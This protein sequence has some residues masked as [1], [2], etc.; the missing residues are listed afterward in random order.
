MRTLRYGSVPFINAWPLTRGLDLAYSE[1]P[2]R[3]AGR[4]RRG[5]VDVALLSSFE[6]FR[7]GTSAIVPGIAI[8]S[9]GPVGSV[10]LFR[11]GPRE[12]LRRVRV[13][14]SSL[15][16]AALVRLLLPEGVEFVPCRPELDPREA[17]GDGVLLIGD[18]AMVAPRDGLV[19]DDLAT[20]WMAE[21]GLP[22]TFAVW[23]A[24]DEATAEA[25]T[26]ELA[27]AKDRGLASRAELAAAAA[28][29]TGLTREGL[30]VYLTK[31]ITYDLGPEELL[32]LG[33]FEA[34]CRER[35]LV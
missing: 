33:L 13:D 9:A 31:Q 3:L 16:S 6:T 14:D 29:E 7:V 21:T 27:A 12:E 34:R 4:F 8:A 35:G 5:E 30:F 11:R 10:L 28:A 20:L 2:S 26:A 24:R 15:T 22:F 32:G 1:V 17:G 23:L 18:A 25:A 19:V